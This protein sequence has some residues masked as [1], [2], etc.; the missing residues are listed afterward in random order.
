MDV[1]CPRCNTRYEFDEAL[2]S[3]R[4]TTVKCTS[5]SHQFKVYRPKG[6]AEL[7]GWTIRTVDGRELRYDAMRKLQAAITNGEITQD[8]VLIPGDGG[9]PKRLAKIEELQSFFRS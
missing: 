8:D 6:A 9:E 5:C 2:V 1:T 7:D 4:G 3:S